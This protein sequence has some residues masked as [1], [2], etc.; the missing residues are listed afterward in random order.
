MTYSRGCTYLIKHPTHIIGTISTMINH[1]YTT[2]LS[3]NI[4]TFTLLHGLTD[5]FQLLVSTNIWNSNPML[6][7]SDAQKNFNQ[8]L[9]LKIYVKL[10]AK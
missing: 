1:V 2:N 3:H 10:Y 4:K 5:H 9:F 8:K 6:Y 7:L